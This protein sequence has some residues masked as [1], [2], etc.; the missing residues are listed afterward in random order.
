MLAQ[1]CQADSATLGL[2]LTR[3][4]DAAVAA[5]PIFM[6][7]PPPPP[8]SCRI[9]AFFP[10]DPGDVL[11]LAERVA[12]VGG[13]VTVVM[14]ADQWEEASQHHAGLRA[15]SWVCGQKQYEPPWFQDRD[16][17]QHLLQPLPTREAEIGTAAGPC[18]LCVCLA[19]SAQDEAVGT[20]TLGTFDRAWDRGGL[21]HAFDTGAGSEDDARAQAHLDK[22]LLL[23]SPS[24]RALV[25][26]NETAVATR[27]GRSASTPP[28]GAAVDADSGGD[29]AERGMSLQRMR[30]I[31]GK[32]LRGIEVHMGRTG[33]RVLDTPAT[34]NVGATAGA[35]ASAQ[36]VRMHVFALCVP[37]AT[38]Q[39][40][41]R[42]PSCPC[43][44]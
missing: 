7:A 15:L 32:T 10:A 3:D 2:W 18:R 41:F 31:A 8:P 20:H 34:A 28:P 23:L 4:A 27:C 44:R 25:F 42:P 40:S 38:G 13:S 21:Q 39:V 26:A 22:L 14:P 17:V 5:G 29:A 24:A 19:S 35:S 11:V 43:C 30:R 16:K 33:I 6:L 12:G 37:D 1:L 9:L 36:C